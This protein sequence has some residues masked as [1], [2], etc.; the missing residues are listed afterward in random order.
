MGVKENPTLDAYIQKPEKTVAV[1]EA[2]TTLDCLQPPEEEE[3]SSSTPRLDFCKAILSQ[4]TS[5]QHSWPRVA[6]SAI[7]QRYPRMPRRGWELLCTTYNSKF[8]ENLCK[9]EMIKRA[10]TATH[11]ESGRK[12]N[13][14]EYAEEATKKR[15]TVQEVIEEATL[16]DT[17]LMLETRE[18]FKKVLSDIKT[19]PVEESV[20]TR[21]LHSDIVDR[22]V[23]QRLNQAVDEWKTS[24][25]ITTWTEMA[26]ILQ[27]VQVT[28]E[29]IKKPKKK[30]GPSWRENIQNKIQK[31][32]QAREVLIKFRMFP[33]PTDG[34]KEARKIMR[35]MG[36]LLSNKEELE[37]AIS[38][39]DGK[40]QIYQRKLDTHEK[41]K[42]F[43]TVN[44]KY[45]VQRSRFY[46]DLE[47]EVAPE[48]EVEEEKVREFWSTMWNATEGDK[49][50]Y[51]EYLREFVP[52]P[53]DPQDVF[54]S[55]AEF[56]DI[57][58]YLPNWKAAGVDGIY[59]FFIKQCTSLH[60]SLY[61][62]IRRTCKEQLNCEQW[63]FKGITYLL[64]KG[65]PKKGGDFRPI[66]C[67]SNLYKLTTKCVTAV[68]QQVVELR[69]LLSEAQL[70][71]VRQVQGAKEQAMINIAINSAT[72]NK[73][74][75]AWIDVKK[76][77]DSVEH[78]YLIECLEK[79]NLPHWIV[80]FLKSA[81]AR[82]QIDIKLQNNTILTKDIKRGI[83][84]GD[85]L[86]PLLFVLCMDPV[87]KKLNFDYP[88]LEIK[89]DGDNYT[90]NHLL[91]IDDL[92]LFAEEE[93][94]LKHMLT[95]VDK[96]F[97]AVG[98]ERNQDK[99]ATNTESCKEF[100]VLLGVN[101]GYKYLGVTENRSSEVMASTFQ[102][103]KKEIMKRV[104][105]L[106]K[107]GL[108]GR[109]LISSINEYATSL[110]NYYIG[111]IPAEQKDYQEIDQEIRTI[112]R[113]YKIHFQPANTERLYL[114]RQELGRGLTNVVMKSERIELQLYLALENSRHVSLRRA[115][116]LKVM[117]R[118]KLSVALIVPYL[119]N[120][121]KIETEI[122]MDM[123]IE[124]QKKS[125][126]N[127]IN[128]K[129]NH[130][131]L[132]GF[133]EN[134]I[135]S[136]KDSALW[137]TK[138]NIS[139]TDEGYL[140]LLQDRNLYGDN[141][142]ACPHCREA[143]KTVDHLATRCKQMLGYFYTH[144]HN[145]VVKAVH[146]FLCNKYGLVRSKRIRTHSVQEIN[147]NDDVEIRVDTTV[148]T[149]IKIS[150]NRP[151]IIVIDKKRKE[152]TFIEIGITSQDQLITVEA[153]K[154]HKYELAA[155]EMGAIHKCKTRIIPYVMTWDGIVTQFHTKHVKA[156]GL[157]QK[158]EAYIQYIVLKKTQESI[159]SDYRRGVEATCEDGNARASAM[160]TGSGAVQIE[161]V[162]EAAEAVVESKQ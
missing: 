105:A 22:E 94:T 112:L 160:E 143:V 124:A 89:L 98:L 87:S 111:V 57:I 88:K 78:T 127:E 16:R 27:A 38:R 1:E 159:T 79:L 53:H 6:L 120:R 50:D 144:R 125:L 133:L 116:I 30:E 63:F 44:R 33:Q 114:P 153:E 122:T 34:L 37:T 101:E 76:A 80:P 92:K 131:K 46:R 9:T 109:N 26:Q 32:A 28:Y 60:E 67:M 21:K 65:V 148:D 70:G 134:K 82:W 54:P 81:I 11:S 14:S 103:A 106:C 151:D 52:G 62:L 59:N 95:E 141:P 135:A 17:K 149:S 102:K 19:K 35:E 91:F 42:Q 74:K 157:T 71:T 97:A 161:E 96:F 104:E 162:E 118:E 132:Y 13:R 48:I 145:E 86:S 117:Q 158:I 25:P 61:L 75:S 72:G 154:Q 73:A 47:G 58:R 23:I 84:Q 29:E 3:S 31:H 64:P 115:A 12:L 138:G 121:Y 113:K 15:K 142:G 68:I 140:S 128:K 110:L 83:L 152:I 90:A 43:S 40:A 55:M 20:R 146:F 156:I 24:H 5:P 100:G 126:Y 4:V 108:N 66:T 93:E 139:A 51:S 99:S 136:A 130:K 39:M 69:G 150:A 41:R 56:Q 119:Q 10:E 2:N 147:A 7:L 155:R 137:L 85:S 107:V 129:S 8:R 36:L 77:F 18:K 49:K 45:E 123:L